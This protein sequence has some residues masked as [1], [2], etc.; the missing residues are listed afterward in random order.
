MSCP[1]IVPY[2]GSDTDLGG[3]FAKCP[4]Y[5]TL[6]SGKAAPEYIFD[7]ANTYNYTSGDGA[8]AVGPAR[9]L[10]LPVGVMDTYENWDNFV[11]CTGPVYGAN[12]QD[13]KA[14]QTV[15]NDIFNAADKAGTITDDFRY[16]YM[17]KNTNTPA[18]YDLANPGNT[19]D[20]QMG[21]TPHMFYGLVEQ[22]AKPVTGN[23]Q[24]GGANCPQLK[25][26][27][28]ENDSNNICQQWW[29]GATGDTVINANRDNIYDAV[30][31]TYCSKCEN[32]KPTDADYKDYNGC[33][34]ACSCVNKPN[35]PDTCMT[36]G[37]AHYDEE[38]CKTYRIL[39]NNLEDSAGVIPRAP[40]WYT[41]CM[42]NTR[43]D[44][45]QGYLTNELLLT[46]N[47]S[48][49]Q[50][51]GN[52]TLCVDNSSFDLDKNK[53]HNVTVDHNCGGS[54]KINCVNGKPN[55]AGTVCICPKGYTGT[56][57]ENPPT[58]PGPT[59][60]GPTPPTPSPSTACGK[61]GKLKADGKTCECIDNY[62]GAK[63]DIAPPKKHSGKLT[64]WELGVICAVGV[65]AVLVLFIWLAATRA[66]HHTSTPD[67]SVDA[68][69]ATDALQ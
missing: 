64:S 1:K 52:I 10:D 53:V 6:A 39:K 47:N 57:C 59:P 49:K 32:R 23:C 21:A 66:R 30:V 43:D 38:F 28:V 41:P 63:C 67:T 44:S 68:D 37:S 42:V 24:G 9:G 22:C 60:P 12:V 35:P 65:V 55:S 17:G 54:K 27:G 69:R 4:K 18:G 26:K 48:R 62:T 58:P 11:N 50:C 45:A 20:I 8:S 40:C 25:Q 5:S 13:C 3:R 29:K 46:N 31:S 19:G 36:P 61:H 14:N 2:Y 51:A 34:D 15:V 16:Q 7:G 33:E 56:H